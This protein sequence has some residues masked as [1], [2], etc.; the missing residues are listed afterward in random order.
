MKRLVELSRDQEV[1]TGTLYIVSTPIGN[2]KDISLRALDVLSQVDLIAAEDT[3]KS[4]ILL[5]RYA[6]LSSI[7]SLHSYN[8]KKKTPGLVRRLLDGN[9]IAV[10]SDAGTPGIS[11]PAYY[12]V[13]QAIKENITI[14]AI[15][16][17]AAFV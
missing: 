11:D 10:I 2:L 9:S 15:P 14:E 12:F 6:I 16:G 5:N 7:T 17:P 13:S 3:R 8:Q 1:E 4:R